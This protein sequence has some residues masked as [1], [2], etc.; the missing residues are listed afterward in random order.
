MN[1]EDEEGD[2]DDLEQIEEWA[3]RLQEDADQDDDYDNQQDKDLD[4]QNVRFESQPA[5]RA[6]TSQD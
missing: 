6:E 4:D 5:E 2:D 1:L 3:R